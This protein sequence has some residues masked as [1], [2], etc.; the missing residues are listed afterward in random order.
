MKGMRVMFILMVT[1]VMGS[2]VTQQQ[3]AEEK[4]RMQEM[5]V[6]AVAKK[7]WRID[8]TVLP[9]PELPAVQPPAPELFPA[10]LVYPGH[11]CRRAAR[12]HDLHRSEA[13]CSGSPLSELLALQPLP[14]VS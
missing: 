7:Q 11:T 6:E 10:V 1:V 14:C 2:C 3:R 9:G 12:P 4:A 8:V 13:V 5:V